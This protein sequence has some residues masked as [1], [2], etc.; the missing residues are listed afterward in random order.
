MPSPLMLDDFSSTVIANSAG[1]SGTL[2]E[3]A[4]LEAFEEGYKAGWD[5]VVAAQQKDTH[6]IGEDL[7]RNLS[8]LSFTYHEV[9]TNILQAL[10]PLLHEILGKVLPVSASAALPE[11][12]NE[13]VSDIAD[14]ATHLPILITVHPD[15][16]E[17]VGDLI[18]ESSSL[19]V[20]THAD[21]SL[22]N[23][24]AMI[25]FADQEHQIDLDG[26]IANMNAAL[27]DFFEAEFKERAN[28]TN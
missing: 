25:K 5:D 8:D 14:S 28:G 16:V 23:G 22:T 9:R 4:R 18:P 3:D 27:K 1:D 2:S 6:R 21:T 20:S 15:L 26:A 7:A 24:Q 17:T 13:H 12:I 10:R 19:P 11:L